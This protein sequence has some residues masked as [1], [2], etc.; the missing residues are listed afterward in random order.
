MVASMAAGPPK[1]PLLDGGAPEEGQ[2]ELEG[3]ACLERL[4]GEIAVVAA[5]NSEEPE[6]EEAHA[7]HYFESAEAGVERE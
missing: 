7:E 1:G 5:G 2:E 3:A 6:P 4:V